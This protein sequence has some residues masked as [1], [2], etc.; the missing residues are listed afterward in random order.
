MGGSVRYIAKLKLEMFFVA[1]SGLFGGVGWLTGRFTG[2]GE[3]VRWLVMGLTRCDLNRG[4]QGGP[5]RHL[6]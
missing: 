1:G 6:M 5:E 3:T 4:K 2:T